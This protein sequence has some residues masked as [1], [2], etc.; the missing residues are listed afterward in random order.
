MEEQ[1]KIEE[2]S[3]KLKSY[4]DTRYDLIVLNTSDKVSIIGSQF[5]AYLI[6]GILSLLFIVLF[7]IALSLYISSV[8]GSSFIGFFAVG[9]I[10]LV[11]TILLIVFKKQVTNPF[12]NM[13]IRAVLNETR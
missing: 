13:I 2:L 6:I 12:R 3:D 11:L 4:I 7:S 9:G 5:I 8:Y 10:Y 1:T